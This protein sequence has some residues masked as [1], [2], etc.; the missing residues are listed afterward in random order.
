MLDAHIAKREKA[1]DL[2]V[3]TLDTPIAEREKKKAE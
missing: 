3:R 1:G 2:R